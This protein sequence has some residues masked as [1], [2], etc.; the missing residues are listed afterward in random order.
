LKTFYEVCE[1]TKEK[2]GRPLKDKEVQFLQW[3]Y[4]RYEKEQAKEFKNKY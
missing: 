4:K 1:D 2:L 3:L